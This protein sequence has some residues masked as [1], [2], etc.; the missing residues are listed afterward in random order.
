MHIESL[1]YFQ[2]IA[3][4]KSISKVANNSHISQPALSQQIQK[5]EDSLGERLFIRS[6]RGVKLTKSGEIVLKYADNIIRTYNKMLS[7]LN[8]QES[9]EIK[10]EGEHTIATYCLPCAI[11]NMQFKFP[12]HKYNLVS[13]SSDKI[14][15]DVL[16]DIC[17]IG[18]TTHPAQAEN[19]HSEEV[20]NEKVVLISP[21]AFDL[22]EKVELQEVLDYKFVI[23][24]EDCII[25]ENFKDAL[26]DLGSNFSEIEVISQLDST[27]AIKTLVRKGYGVAFVPYNAV[28]DEFSAK[29]INVS[30]I[31]DYDLDYDIYMI[32]KKAEFLTE[33]VKEFIANFKK[34]G[35]HICY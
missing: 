30:R 15:Q 6:N 21:P 16:S 17:E 33:N 8:E 34:L 22:P 9:R 20:I 12:N 10:I 11:L 5:L 7:D 1:E 31:T 18:F 25:K 3:K 29:E 14:E 28:R 13:A 4:I 19:L 35:K 32:N 26:A 23:L 24:K 27:E 2:E